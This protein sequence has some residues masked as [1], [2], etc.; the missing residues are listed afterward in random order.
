MN[1]NA[2]E[3][4]L[5]PPSDYWGIGDRYYTEGIETKLAEFSFGCSKTN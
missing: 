5:K 4:T 3:K 1:L 2:S